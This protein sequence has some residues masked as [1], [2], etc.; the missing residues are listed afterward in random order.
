MRKVIAGCLVAVA[1]LTGCT[2]A[3]KVSQNVSQQADNFN[4]VRR[5]TVINARSDK[6]VFELVAAFSIQV[7]SDENQLEVICEVGDGKY[8]KHFIGL[9]DWTIYVVEDVGGADVSKYHYEVNFLPEMIKPI[10]ITNED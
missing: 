7:D 8:K 6:P 4:V 2:Q 9:N 3:D 10:T 1:C 5:L